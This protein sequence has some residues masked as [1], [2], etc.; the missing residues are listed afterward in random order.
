[1]FAKATG[2]DIGKVKVIRLPDAMGAQAA[3]MLKGKQAD[4]VFGFVNTIIA[5]VAPLGIDGRKD[6]HFLTY[7]EHLPDMYGNTLFVT[8]ELY[9]ADPGALKGMVRAFNRALAD[10]IKTPDAAIDALVRRDANARRDVNHTRLVG[11]FKSDMAHP[12]GGRIG[13]ATWT[14]AG[15]SA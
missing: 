2:I 3:E 14:T 15:S 12:E 11:T 5:S 13:S 1:M 10:A 7:A 4:G 8:R 6:L 9:R